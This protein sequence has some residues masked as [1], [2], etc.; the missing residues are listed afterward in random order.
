MNRGSEASLQMRRNITRS[1]ITQFYDDTSPFFKFLWHRDS[2]SHAL[3]FGFWEKHTKSHKEAL[4]NTNKFLADKAQI[5]PND[6]ILD[7]GCGI[8]GSAIWIAKNFGV[9]VIGIS[10]SETQVQKAKEL[11]AMNNTDHLNRF[12]MGDFLNTAFRDETFDIVWAIESICHAEAKKDFLIEASRLLKKNGKMVLSDGFLLRDLR[13]HTEK[14]PLED[15]MNGMVLPNLDMVDQ[16]KK[17]LRE[18]GF[19]NIKYWEK[20]REIM[21]S[22]RRLYVLS[23]IC[24]PLFLLSGKLRITKDALTKSSRAGIALFKLVKLGLAGYGVF[25]AEK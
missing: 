22:L 24:Y 23:L 25:Y 13:N 11:A 10:L 20:T 17:S 12:L 8:G 18:V 16:F 19:R 15:F 1:D 4:L 14:R 7:A 6:I 3:H 2:E 5:G 9:I 21:P